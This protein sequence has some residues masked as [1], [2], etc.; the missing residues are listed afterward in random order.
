[1]R[2]PISSGEAYWSR[3]SR[4]PRAAARRIDASLPAATQNGGCGCCAGGGSTTMSLKVQNL[5]LCEKRSRDVQAR[6]MTSSAS[7]KRAS[8]SSCGMLKPMNSL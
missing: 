1:M 6:V 7:S 3:I 8:A 2:R 4:K 5:P